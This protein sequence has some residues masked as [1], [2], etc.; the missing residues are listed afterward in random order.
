MTAEKKPTFTPQQM[1]ETYP[2]K[3]GLFSF[4]A[5]NIPGLMFWA[6]GEIANKPEPTAL[7][8]IKWRKN[9]DC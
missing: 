9:N 4:M 8:E 1:D 3:H 5:G 6:N 2:H 7:P